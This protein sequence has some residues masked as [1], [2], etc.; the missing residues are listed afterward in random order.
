MEKTTNEY[1][2]M[3]IEQYHGTFI[4]YKHEAVHCAIIDVNNTIDYAKT[5]GDVTELDVNY[6]NEVLTILK[7]ML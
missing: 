3:L 2:E 6:F 7:S 4:I 5:F 1:A